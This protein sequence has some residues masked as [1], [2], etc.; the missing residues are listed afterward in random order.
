[1]CLLACVILFFYYIYRYQ[2]SLKYP[3]PPAEV[4]KTTKEVER[5]AS[6]L[7]DVQLPQTDSLPK[8]VAVEYND[9]MFARMHCIMHCMICIHAA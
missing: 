3:I 5:F 1:M 7:V 4:E 9:F 8:Y 2:V 6:E